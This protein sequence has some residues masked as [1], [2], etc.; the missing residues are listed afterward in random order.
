VR[1]NALNDRGSGERRRVRVAVVG[2]GNC[3]SSLVQGVEFYRNATGDDLVVGRMHSDL[4]GYRVGDVEFSAAF[5]ASRAM[6][7]LDLAEAVSAA[8]NN[9]Y[10][11]AEV[12]GTGVRVERGRRWTGWGRRPRP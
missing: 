4:G 1:R 12:P 9:T 6:V 2:V 10:R 11:F 7:G 3:A 8:P 5:D